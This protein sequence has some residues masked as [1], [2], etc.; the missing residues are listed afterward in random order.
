MFNYNEK[1]ITYVSLIRSIWNSNLEAS[2]QK[3][4]N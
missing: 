1:K 2:W 3:S 4:L